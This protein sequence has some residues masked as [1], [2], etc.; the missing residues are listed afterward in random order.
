MDQFGLGQGALVGL[1]S[2]LFFIAVTW[3]ALQAV[4]FEKFIKK[5]RIVQARILLILLTVAI[6]AL[7]SNFFM[8]Y[9]D[10]SRQL[11]SLF[12]V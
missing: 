11:P 3:W 10:W 6:A 5:N 12:G 2:H 8:D 4:N 9:Y 1:I 7:V